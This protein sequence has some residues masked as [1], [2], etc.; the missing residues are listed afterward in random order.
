MIFA[1]RGKL[2]GS[3]TKETTFRQIILASTTAFWDAYLKRDESAQAWL[4]GEGFA[5][6]LGQ[7]GVFEK[8]V[9]RAYPLGRP[10]QAP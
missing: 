7:D 6:L 4:E 3:R 2:T 9:H 1:G 10:P 8:K 5:S